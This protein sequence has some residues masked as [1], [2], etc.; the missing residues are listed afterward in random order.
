MNE[1]KICGRRGVFSLI[2]VASD[3]IHRS[4]EDMSTLYIYTV[5]EID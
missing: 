2:L 5:I 1:V 3:V 4:L